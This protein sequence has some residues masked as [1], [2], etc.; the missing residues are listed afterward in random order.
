MQKRQSHRASFCCNAVDGHDSCRSIGGVLGLNLRGKFGITTTPAL[1]LLDKE[2]AVLC[3]NAQDRLWEDPTGWNFP[4]QD[5]PATPRRPQIGFD[6]VE[7][8]LPEAA[9]FYTH[10]P[11]PQGQIPIFGA[12][13]A[14]FS[15]G[16]PVHKRSR[17]SPW[18]P[19]SKLPPPGGGDKGEQGNH[20]WTC[21]QR[22]A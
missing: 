11:R 15:Q 22:W 17:N 5:P 10:L 3:Q 4:W 2:G 13:Q 6:L 14:L 16:Y 9:P 18:G 20:D 8:S 7:H 19:W 21:D 1:I 12:G